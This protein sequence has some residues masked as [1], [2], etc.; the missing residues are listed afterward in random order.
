MLAGELREY[1]TPPL[2]ETDIMKVFFFIISVHVFFFFSYL[3]YIKN[4]DLFLNNVPI[5]AALTRKLEYY[6]SDFW[7]I[8]FV[9]GGA[10]VILFVFK[11]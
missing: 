9:E 7:F 6:L 1:C 4:I 11:K 2:L 5:K 3:L 10:V 8:S